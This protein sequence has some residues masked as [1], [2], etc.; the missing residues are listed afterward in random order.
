MLRPKCIWLDGYARKACRA[1]KRRLEPLGYRVICKSELPDKLIDKL[2]LE[3][4]CV[5]VTGDRHFAE[6]PVH[7]AAWIYLP[8]RL[9]E[10]RSSAKLATKII[11]MVFTRRP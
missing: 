11:K 6:R 2:A 7:R 5:V 9:A 3:W 8:R 1:L 10:R 4:G